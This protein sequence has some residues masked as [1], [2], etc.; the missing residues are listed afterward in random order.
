M[1]VDETEITR[2]LKDDPAAMEKILCGPAF[3]G[4]RWLSTD[5]PEAQWP[6]FFGRLQTRRHVTFELVVR[7][8]SEGKSDFECFCEVY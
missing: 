5:L 8:D 7:M 1:N 2:D 3:S 6:K 4:L